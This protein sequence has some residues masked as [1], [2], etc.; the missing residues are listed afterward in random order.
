M[1]RHGGNP[2]LAPPGRFDSEL[3]ASQ[4]RKWLTERLGHLP[5][6]RRFFGEELP[7][8]SNAIGNFVAR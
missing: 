7:E 5:Q 6:V 2:I 1:K 4:S 3:F 8:L